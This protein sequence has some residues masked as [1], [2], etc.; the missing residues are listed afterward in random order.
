M[1]GN[2]VQKSYGCFRRDT[3]PEKLLHLFT[4]GMNRIKICRRC[5]PYKKQPGKGEADNRV[6]KPGLLSL[7]NDPRAFNPGVNPPITIAPLPD[8][9]VSATT[10][11]A[12]HRK[13][14]GQETTEHETNVHVNIAGHVNT[15]PC[16]V[17]TVTGHVN[18]LSGHVN[19]GPGHISN[20][21]GIINNK[22]GQMATGPIHV[23]A[24]SVHVNTNSEQVIDA[25]EIDLSVDSSRGSAIEYIRKLAL[26]LKTN[27]NSEPGENNMAAKTDMATPE[28]QI[29]KT[30]IIEQMANF[31]PVTPS[32]NL[33]HQVTNPVSVG[34]NS[35]QWKPVLNQVAPVNQANQANQAVTPETTAGFVQATEAGNAIPT[36]PWSTVPL[37]LKTQPNIVF[38]SPG[39]APHDPLGAPLQT[40]VTTANQKDVKLVPAIMVPSQNALPGQGPVLLQIQRVKLVRDPPSGGRQDNKN[41]IAESQGMCVDIL[42]YIQIVE[43]MLWK[44]V[45]KITQLIYAGQ[46]FCN[47]IVLHRHVCVVFLPKPSI[48]IFELPGGQLS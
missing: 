3:A 24:G 35:V 36:P 44:L 7:P 26:N 45:R 19:N 28:E 16:H 32:M 20:V 48:A 29:M 39:H 25:T 30:P 14:T 31:T 46:P 47:N 6:L 34:A 2:H 8:K 10:L 1:C 9:P 21:A 11:N 27:Y 33:G 13:V 17:N 42:F 23:P 5:L 38:T 43:E 22:S 41:K 15:T 12:I 37:V 40:F 18:N 4:P